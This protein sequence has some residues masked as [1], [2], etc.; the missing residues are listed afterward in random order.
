MTKATI[1]FW[2]MGAL[3]LLGSTA[4]GASGRQAQT[5]PQDAAVAL[6]RMESP[7]AEAAGAS[8]A[9]AVSTLSASRPESGRL[10]YCISG[11]YC[12]SFDPATGSCLA[13]EYIWAWFEEPENLTR[14][15]VE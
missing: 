13:W 5:G 14:D 9:T 15:C 10:H 2:A 8:S 6:T 11:S 1:L 3:V 12:S 7:A 4:D